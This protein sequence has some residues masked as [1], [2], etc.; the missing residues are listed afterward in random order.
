M[1]NHNKKVL[2]AGYAGFIG[3]H[4]IREIKSDNSI[5]IIPISR[6]NGF[7]LSGDPKIFDID[8]DVIVN[9]AGVVGIDRSWRRP[10]D[11]FKDNYLVTLNLLEL[12]R[13]KNASFVHISSYIYGVPQY[14]PVDEKHPIQ[15]HNPYASS[16]I[17]S[18]EICKEYG[19]HYDI[20]VTILRPFNVYGTNQSSKFLLSGLIDSAINGN[21]VDIHDMSAKR[22]YLWVGDLA[23]GIFK[24]VSNQ[25]KGVNIYNI[26]SGV[27]H[28]AKEAIEIIKSKGNNI[29]YSVTGEDSSLLVSDC[30]CDYSLFSR[31]YMWHPAVNL[32]E[33]LSLMLDHLK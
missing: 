10:R 18:E 25:K 15:G 4:L 29:N 21:N 33:G 1:H 27:S 6:S 32:E 20:P 2:I 13:K 30:V 12:A 5:T 31:D 9:L 7:D 24:V 22:D 16:K 17:L 11:F 14:L 28:S 26:G 19:K 23:H 3:S 8:C